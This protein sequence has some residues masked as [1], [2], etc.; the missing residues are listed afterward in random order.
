ML[1]TSI[2]IKLLIILHVTVQYFIY[3]NDYVLL[4]VELFIGY[5]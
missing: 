1:F 4:H 5:Y 3:K 2:Y